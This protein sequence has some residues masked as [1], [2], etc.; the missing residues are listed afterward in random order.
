M[1]A[2]TLQAR[3][4]E[5]FTLDSVAPQR[6]EQPATDEAVA[7][8]LKAAAGAGQAVVPWGAGTKQQMGNPPRAYDVAVLLTGLDGIVEYE[9]AD[10]VVTAQAG[11][12]LARLQARLAEAGQFLALDP[13][14][15]EQATLG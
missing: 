9:P 12:P 5:P 13:P 2:T 6:V 10:L 8:L 14:Y 3:P 1:S 11:V 7:T 15:A 4:G